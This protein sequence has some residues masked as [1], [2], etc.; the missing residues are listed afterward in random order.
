[1]V[2]VHRLLPRRA[3]ASLA[4]ARGIPWRGQAVWLRSTGL[5]MAAAPM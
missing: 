3:I 5:P 4:S 1:M 2:M